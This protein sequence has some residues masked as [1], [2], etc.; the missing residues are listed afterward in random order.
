MK[1][2]LA[3]LAALCHTCL[4]GAGEPA[5]LKNMRPDYTYAQGK[6]LAAKTAKG[7]TQY[8]YKDGKLARKWLPGGRTIDYYYDRNG[9]L[10]E[11][12][13]STGLVRTYQRD[14]LGRLRQIVGS[15][16]YTKTLRGPAGEKML[17]ITGP[18]NYRLD[19]TSVV[20]KQHK[21]TVSAL[22][23]MRGTTVR[24]LLEH[25][26]GCTMKR[27]SDSGAEVGSECGEGGAWFGDPWADD[28]WGGDVGAGEYGD[29]SGYAA[30]E[31]EQWD[32]GYGGTDTEWI[33]GEL[34]SRPPERGGP[35]GN[36][37]YQA[38]MATV[39]EPAD[40]KFRDVCDNHAPP[41]DRVVCNRA[42]VQVYFW[43]E[44]DCRRRSY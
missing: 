6:I 2:Y 33:G 19:L 5:V 4:A 24:S 21:S 34:G 43:C 25:S 9:K 29:D 12:R 18:K 16:G 26:D 38:C 32:G 22:A 42:T 40:I 44:A 13:F 20:Q 31:D 39:C 36:L 28:P 10:V 37:A 27:F 15:N 3:A 1:R 41:Q 14:R 23:A 8:E 17:V 30:D 35:R 11:S 7:V